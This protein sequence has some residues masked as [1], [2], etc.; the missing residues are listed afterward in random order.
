MT[1]RQR[2]LIAEIVEIL[3][4]GS[5][6]TLERPRQILHHPPAEGA[7]E[8]EDFILAVGKASH[9]GTSDR[10]RLMVRRFRHP[11]NEVD[12]LRARSAAKHRAAVKGNPRPNRRHCEK[13]SDE[14]IQTV[15][16]LSERAW[17]ASR[18]LSSGAHSR[19]VGSQSWEYIRRCSIT[20]GLSQAEAGARQNRA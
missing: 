17:I 1:P 18:S 20:R 8:V 6:R 9:H 12:R 11:V 4:D 5:R 19:P 13:Q 15:L 10:I 2:P 14:A 3:A 16:S 7:G